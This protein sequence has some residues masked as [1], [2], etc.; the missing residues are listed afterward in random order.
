MTGTDIATEVRRTGPDYIVYQPGSL[1]GSTYD[2]GNEHFLVFDGPDGSLMAVW[3]QSSYEGAGDHRIMFTRS[4]EEGF[5]W[6]E[7]V[8]IAGPWQ[9][10]E[11]HMA[12][13]G[14]PLVSRS[15]RIYVIWNQYQ[16]IDDVVHQHTGTMDCSYSDDLGESWS[17]PMTIPMPRSPYDSPDQNVPSNWIVWQIPIR[18]LRG[19]WFTGFSR[20]VGPMCQPT[21]RPSVTGVAG[22]S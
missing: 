8:R 6:N 18:D 11:G 10:G 12:S 4:L 15:G 22:R 13:W 19:R 21:P 17:P 16:G 5:T 9:P 20:W 7:P 14:F 3:T 2:T 1:D